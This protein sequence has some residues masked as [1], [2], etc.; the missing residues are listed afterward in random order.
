MTKQKFRKHTVD[1]V[2]VLA[3][4][5][6]GTPYHH[7]ASCLGVGV[8]CLGLVRGVWCDLYGAD[9]EEPPAYARDWA[10]A[11][12]EE[13]ML[14]AARRHLLERCDRLPCVGDV[15]IFRYRCGYVAKHAGIMTGVDSFVHAVE[16][17]QVCEV[18]FSNWWRRRM[19]AAFAFPGTG[20]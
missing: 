20:S 2:V 18:A 15:L 7:Q 6:I 11:K 14:A 16:G 12:G 8:D 10:E 17:R 9:A 3:R 19:V 5:W 4:Q 1:E 13:T